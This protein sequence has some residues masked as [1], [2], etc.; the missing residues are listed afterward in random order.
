MRLAVVAEY[1]FSV[2][3]ERHRARPRMDL[4]IIQEDA[5]QATTSRL[6][7]FI[8][9]ELELSGRLTSL[10]QTEADKITARLERF[11]Q[12]TEPP[13]ILRPMFPGCGYVD[14]SE[15][16]VISGDIIYEIKTV[17]RPVRSADI[18]QVITYAALNFAS[19]QFTINKM[20]LV[21]P[22][23]AYYF[24]FDFDHVCAE[25]AGMSPPELFRSIIDAVS[26]GEISR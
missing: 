6:A 5:W 12:D 26:S 13:L 4:E 17:H 15:G 14:K 11:F 20:G 7:P 19:K 24:H 23:A 22:R 16:D 25:I 1:A 3:V 21:N 18:R 9:R 10:E 8:G 2:F